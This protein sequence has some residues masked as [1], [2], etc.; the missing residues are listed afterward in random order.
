MPQ[1][2]RTENSSSMAKRSTE[3]V[4]PRPIMVEITCGMCPTFS[5]IVKCWTQEQVRT[6]YESV[7]MAHNMLEHGMK[8]F[9]CADNPASLGQS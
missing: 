8:G 6:E 1:M 2:R 5:K 9:T 7:M 4:P 3:N